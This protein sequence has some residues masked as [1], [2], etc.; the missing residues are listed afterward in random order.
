M[1]GRWMYCSNDS[2]VVLYPDM[3][4]G[5]WILS[6]IAVS[7]F[8][9]KYTICQVEKCPYALCSSSLIIYTQ[10]LQ[11]STSKIWYVLPR[12][13][14][15]RLYYPIAFSSCSRKPIPLPTP[16]NITRL[17]LT[18]LPRPPLLPN[19]LMPRWRWIH[20]RLHTW[21]A[22]FRGTSTKARAPCYPAPCAC[23]RPLCWRCVEQL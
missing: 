15:S 19:R 2:C 14:C 10:Y 22:T 13:P 18:L 21:V 16:I 9:Y 8:G 12:G 20:I 7:T 1:K 11:Q 3:L 5:V 17:I 23:L 6:S 4:R